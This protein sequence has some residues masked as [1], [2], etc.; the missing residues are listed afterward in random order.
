M[1]TY[2]VGWDVAGWSCP[3]SDSANPQGL[4]QD[5]LVLLTS[6]DKQLTIARLDRGNFKSRILPSHKSRS[7][8]DFIRD[9]MKPD[10]NF[11]LAID[12]PLGW[13]DEFR[14]LLDW[15]WPVSEAGYES[16][17]HR[18]TE[19]SQG[20]LSSVSHAIGSASTKALAYL[21]SQKFARSAIAGEYRRGIDIAI[22]TY[23]APAK[24]Y[25][26]AT[27]KWI[28]ANAHNNLLGQLR[29]RGNEDEKDALWCAL[30]AAVRGKALDGA[31]L[32]RPAEGTT[33]SEGWIWLPKLEA[34]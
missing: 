26:K 16:L 5:A 1:T 8:T 31:R 29:D 22:E 18:K 3:G 27:P 20:G 2:Y 12:A 34:T 32:E 9:L 13:P 15:E 17:I 21:Q 24:D 19:I 4:S 6:V 28:L 14:A 10:D 25:A 11:V 23:P 7:P 30:I 33:L